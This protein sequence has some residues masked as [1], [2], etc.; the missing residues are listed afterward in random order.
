[1]SLASMRSWQP[2]LKDAPSHDQ[3]H[4]QNG[5]ASAQTTLQKLQKLSSTHTH[6]LSLSLQFI[7]YDESL[8]CIS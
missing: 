2:C 7:T 3:D 1:M 4:T 8:A 6:F 5:V